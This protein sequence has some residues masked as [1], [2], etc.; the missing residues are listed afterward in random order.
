MGSDGFSFNLDLKWALAEIDRISIGLKQMGAPAHR[1]SLHQIHQV[2]SE[3]SIRKAWEVL[4][5]GCGHELTAGNPPSLEARHQ[6]GL[7][8]GSGGVDGRCISSRP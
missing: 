8:V 3:H 1:L 4:D 5:V 2:R 6:G 7:K